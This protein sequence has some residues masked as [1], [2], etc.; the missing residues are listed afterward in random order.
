MLFTFPSRYWFAIGLSGVFSLTGWSRL[1]HAEF[2]VLRAT[3]DAA[4]VHVASNTRLSRRFA[5]GRRGELKHLSTRR[6]RKQNVIPPV[7]ASERGAAQT[8]SVQAAAGFGPRRGKNDGEWNVPD[9]T[10]AEGDSPV[11]EAIRSLAVSRVARDTR[12]PA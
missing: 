10:A 4:T 5:A 7:V 12:N 6:K 2:L 11:H 1:V 3:Q 9:R 8:A